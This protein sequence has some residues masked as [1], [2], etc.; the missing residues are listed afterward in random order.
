MYKIAKLNVDDRR[1]LFRNTAA[2]MHLNEAIVEKDFW[3]CITLEYLFHT[4]QFK[5]A[6]AFKG[7]A[8]Y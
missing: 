1:V 7:M 8:C 5:D 2:K 6:F 4:C 3:V